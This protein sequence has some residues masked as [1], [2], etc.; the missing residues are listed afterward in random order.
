ML[1]APL[2]ELSTAASTERAS[3]ISDASHT[4]TIV[5][6]QSYLQ[7]PKTRSLF[8]PSVPIPAKKKLAKSTA[9]QLAQR[10]QFLGISDDGKK[11]SALILTAETGP[12]FFEIGDRMGQFVLKNIQ[13]DKLVLQLHDE[14]VILKR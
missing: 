9:E 2:P 5:P 12:A 7:L 1:A 3:L 6:L 14:Q 11:L 4:R 13:K 10:L 8:K